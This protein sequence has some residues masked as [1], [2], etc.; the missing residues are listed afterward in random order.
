MLQKVSTRSGQAHFRYNDKWDEDPNDPGI[1]EFVPLDDGARHTKWM[2]FMYPRL[3]IMREMLRPGGVLA[4]C[5]DHRELF[6]LGQMLDELFG[7]N[8]RLAVINWQKS[9]S[10]RNDNRH[11]S[12]ATEYV[13]VYAR[14]ES[15]AKTNLLPRTDEMDARYASADGDPRLWKSGDLTAKKA[16]RNQGMVYAIQ[17]PF[18]GELHYPP[19][20]SCWRPAQRELLAT[21]CKWGTRYEL[22]S[23]KDDERRAEIIGLPVDEI[24]PAKALVLAK[25]TKQ[26]RKAAEKTLSK[27]SWPRV[28][29]G[30]DGLGRPQQKNFLEEV[31]QGKVPLTYWADEDYGSPQ[32]LDAVS[33]AHQESGHSQTGI[34]EL[35]A[36]L[37][38]NHRFETVKPLKLFKKILQLWCPPKGLVLD[39]FGGSG[40]TAHAVLEQNEVS[41]A[42]RRFIL[43][44]QGRPERGDSYARS[45]L[46]ERLGRV[47]SGD[48]VNGKGE[49]VSGGFTFLSLGKKVDA[50][51]LLQMER[52]E[53]VDTVIASHFDSTRRRGDQLVRV[54]P[55]RG[56][57]Y[58]YLVAKNA[59]GE[60]FFLVWDGANKNTDFTEAVYEVCAEEAATAGLKAFPYHVY[61]RLYRYQ[62]DGVRFYQIPDRILADFGVD[63][64]SEP[65]AEAAEEVT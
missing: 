8:N 59:D 39:P 50:N 11:V 21:L 47:I 37:G 55:A 42:S 54:E 3:Q 15:K 64:K 48:W 35:D 30:K 33:W 32:V 6:R 28:Y 36:I 44:E 62:T 43:I 14:D 5:I 53:M 16:K 41:G 65:F 51:A 45:L 61:A 2:R 40:T 46:A 20:G 58:R 60:G 26:A 22:K 52:G 57:Q 13:L 12:T 38:D 4:I 34:S 23:L 63:L 24:Q 17:S 9:Y 25:P 10:P 31:K 1:G 27:G 19:P 56:R 18:T 29:F 7:E 49:P